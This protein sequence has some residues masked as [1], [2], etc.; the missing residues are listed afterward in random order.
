MASWHGLAL[1]GAL[2]ALPCLRCAVALLIRADRAAVRRGWRR[3]PTIIEELHG[4]DGQVRTRPPRSSP[5][6]EQI[7]GELRRLQRLRHYGLATQ[8]EV[9]LAAV[10]DSYDRWLCEG[11]QTLGVGEELRRLDGLDKE[12]ERARIEDLLRAKGF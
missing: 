1:A 11:C 4:L 6:P 12:L 5:G 10:N 9:W 7:A 8:S 2:L 3:D